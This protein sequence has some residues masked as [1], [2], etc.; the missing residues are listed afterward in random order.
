MSHPNVAAQYWPGHA[1]CGRGRR[2]VS[3]CRDPAGRLGLASD[4]TAPMALQWNSRTWH[5]MPT[6]SLPGPSSAPCTSVRSGGELASSA[7]WTRLGCAES[8]TETCPAVPQ[9]QLRY[10]NELSLKTSLQR[11]DLARIIF[12]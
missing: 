2:A 6:A 11:A 8:V 3:A 1:N 12:R 4:G 5:P 9:T 10:V 7:K